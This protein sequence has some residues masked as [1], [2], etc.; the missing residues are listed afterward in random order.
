MVLSKLKNKEKLV[1]IGHLI[2]ITNND[3]SQTF[4]ISLRSICRFV[5]KGIKYYPQLLNTNFGVVEHGN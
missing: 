3:L 4:K 2:G 5:A 1:F